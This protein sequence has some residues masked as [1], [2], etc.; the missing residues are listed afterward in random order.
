MKF[1]YPPVIIRK[2]ERLDYY[3][4]LETANLGDVKPFI[5][6]IAQA[7]Q[8]TLEEYIRVCNNS[9]RLSFE[10]LKM[11]IVIGDEI[12]A[13]LYE[14]GQIDSEVDNTES[15]KVIGKISFAHEE[16]SIDESYLFNSNKFDQSIYKENQNLKQKK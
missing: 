2:E 10:N 3:Q 4:H 12:T 13:D 1:G 8:R 5:R 14:K 9:H 15:D 11:P 7:V 16:E 6:F